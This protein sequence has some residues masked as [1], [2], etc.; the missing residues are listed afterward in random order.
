MKLLWSLG[1]VIEAIGDADHCSVERLGSMVIVSGAA[2][3]AGHRS[4][5]RRHSLRIVTASF[6]SSEP[7][8]HTSVAAVHARVPSLSAV[9]QA[10]AIDEH[11]GRIV[12][13]S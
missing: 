8:N 3:F 5:H 10:M 13:C 4:A 7:R 1:N 6:A 2:G 9:A 11:G 12:C